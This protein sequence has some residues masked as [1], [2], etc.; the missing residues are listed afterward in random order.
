MKTINKI[1]SESTDYVFEELGR[2]GKAT[3]LRFA[4]VTQLDGVVWIHPTYAKEAT[5]DEMKRH[6][7]HIWRV[8]S[9]W[10]PGQ[11]KLVYTDRLRRA[12]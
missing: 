12:A 8:T 4:P 1:I 7:S 11:P 2:G 9:L 6:A 10:N 5:L 3:I